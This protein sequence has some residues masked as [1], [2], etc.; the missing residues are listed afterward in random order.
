MTEQSMS[1][2]LNRASNEILEATS[3]LSGTNA[4]F[5]EGLYDQ[6]LQNSDS[7]EDG[8][9]NYFAELGEQGLIPTQLG[10]GPAWSRDRKQAPPK[11]EL[12]EA[13][14][15]QAAAPKAPKAAAAP[16]APKGEAGGRAAAL[17]S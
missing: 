1:D 17:D 13:L 12:T 14:S 15:G 2:R 16:D 3:F 6:Y 8:W 10:R 4:A 9:R 11:D 5:L 7:V